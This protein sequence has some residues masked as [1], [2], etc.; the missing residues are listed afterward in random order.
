MASKVKYVIIA[1]DLV[2]GVGIYPSQQEELEIK[3]IVAQYEEFCRLIK[4]I[5][6]DKQII[7]C[8]GNH[9]AVHLYRTAV[10]I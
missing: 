8:P 4:Q 2:D 9:D 7:I 5:P 3:E 1:G 6:A 10:F